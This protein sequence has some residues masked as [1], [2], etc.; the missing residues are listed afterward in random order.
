MGVAVG[1]GV[2]VGVTVG[3]GVGVGVDTTTGVVEN[4][5]VGKGAARLSGRSSALVSPSNLHDLAMGFVI[6]ALLPALF[7]TALVWVGCTALNVDVASGTLVT[8]GGSI[9]LFLTIVCS[10]LVTRT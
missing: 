4:V 10:A 9:A 8:I 1:S 5:G 7:W 3:I 2:G 6:A